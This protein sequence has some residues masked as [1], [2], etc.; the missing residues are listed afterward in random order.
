MSTVQSESPVCERQSDHMPDIWDRLVESLRRRLTERVSNSTNDLFILSILTAVGN[1]CAHMLVPSASAAQLNIRERQETSRWRQIQGFS[2]GGALLLSG[3]TARVGITGCHHR[4]K[5]VEP[6][7]E[8]VNTLLSMGF[9]SAQI[10]GAL[11]QTKNDVNDAVA[12][13]TG[14]LGTGTPFEGVEDGLKD[15]DTQHG[16]DEGEMDIPPLE[17]RKVVGDLFQEVPSGEPPPYDEAMNPSASTGAAAN[18]EESMETGPLE[19]PTT[20]LYELED[21]VFVENWSIPYKREES[22]GKCLLSA[23]RFAQEG[24]WLAGWLCC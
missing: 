14:E 24:G 2:F 18:N 17:D 9:D 6:N 4:Y 15:T 3:L 5:M 1:T 12:L 20:N 22:L 19:F 13:L 23:I 10:R 7:E 21:R 11:A 16:S 8:S